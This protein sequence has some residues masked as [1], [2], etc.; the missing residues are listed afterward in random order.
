MSE[1]VFFTRCVISRDKIVSLLANVLLG[2][3]NKGADA[4]TGDAVLVSARDAMTGNEDARPSAKRISHSEW[5]TRQPVAADRC[6]GRS[7]GASS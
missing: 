3:I 6:I 5:A 2:D 7:S 4:A 1:T